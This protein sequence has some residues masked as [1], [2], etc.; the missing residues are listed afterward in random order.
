MTRH[1]SSHDSDKT[2][3]TLSPPGK[4]AFQACQQR[5]SQLHTQDKQDQMAC[6]VSFCE[7]MLIRRGLSGLTR[8]QLLFYLTQAFQV[9]SSHSIAA[10]IIPALDPLCWGP[11]AAG[12]TA[13]ATPACILLEG[14]STIA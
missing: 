6:Q 1:R 8:Q 2:V 10:G 9:I 14:S 12:L 13:A 7:T 3:T 5:N 11:L 4:S